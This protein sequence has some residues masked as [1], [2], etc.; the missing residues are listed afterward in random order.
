MYNL[1]V[2]SALNIIYALRDK[3]IEKV[4]SQRQI[5]NFL[6]E[7]KKK[8]FGNSGMTFLEF[9]KWCKNNL[10]NEWLGE[11]DSFVLDYYVSLTGNFFF[12]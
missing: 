9:E 1:G 8:K 5:Y 2:K 6:N 3:K 7:Y 12:K 10:K 4:P 11:H